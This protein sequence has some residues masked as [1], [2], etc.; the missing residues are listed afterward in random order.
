MSAVVLLGALHDP[1]GRIGALLPAELPLLQRRYATIVAIC[2]VQT[3]PATVE[4]LRASGVTVISGADIPLNARPYALGVMAAHPEWSH[5][6]LCD[7]DSALHWAHHWPGELDEVNRTI[8][9]HDFLLLGRTARA[10]ASLP[11]A[12]RETERLINLLF[13]RTTGGLDPWRLVDE[14][15]VLIDIC[16][17]AWGFSQRGVAAL[18]ARARI[19]DIGF[20]AE[21]PLSAR[22]TPALRCGYLPCEGLEYETAD[23]YG[24][25]IAAAGGIAAW[26]ATQNADIYHWQQR[27]AY[28]TE[29]AEAIRQWQGNG[30]S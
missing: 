17:G 8:A 11:E 30:I 29:V 2:G 15:D 20:H 26:H 28:I 19:A 9:Q 21:W 27:I 6:H 3:R 22:G 23:R 25:Q 18:R 1:E 7:F 4:G 24:D 13:A 12:Q 14:P 5:V 10:M 16:T